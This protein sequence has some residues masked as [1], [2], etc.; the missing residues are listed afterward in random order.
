MARPWLREKPVWIWE[1]AVGMETDQ[2]AGWDDFP[3]SMS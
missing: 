1:W 3:D 2:R